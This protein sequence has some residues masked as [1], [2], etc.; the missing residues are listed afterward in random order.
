MV[1]HHQI[2]ARVDGGPAQP[3]LIVVGGIVLFRAPMVADHDEL[4]ALRPQ[5]GNI[6]RD[7]LYQLVVTAVEGLIGQSSRSSRPSQS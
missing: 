7:F 5:R 2:G 1:A 3:N 6:G 4:A